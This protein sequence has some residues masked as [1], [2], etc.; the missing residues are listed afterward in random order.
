VGYLNT[1]SVVTPYKDDCIIVKASEASGCKNNVGAFLEGKRKT[2][3]NLS[4]DR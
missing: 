1:L 3:K 2:T 4:Q